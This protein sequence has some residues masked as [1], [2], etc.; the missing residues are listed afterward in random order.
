MMTLGVVLIGFTF[1]GSNS[2]HPPIFSQG[3]KVEDIRL[4]SGH[5][6]GHGCPSPPTKK[7]Q[8]QICSSDVGFAVMLVGLLDAH[9]T[10]WL[11]LVKVTSI[12]P[13]EISEM[14]TVVNSKLGHHRE[15]AC[16]CIHDA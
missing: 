4:L 1:F 3:T 12:N 2:N 16:A 13:G 15:C 5:A 9:S 11:K 7:K 10:I 14:F 8:K 6:K